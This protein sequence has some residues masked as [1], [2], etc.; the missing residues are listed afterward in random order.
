MCSRPSLPW[1]R[2]G[3]PVA[4][5]CT[6]VVCDAP[7]GSATPSDTAATTARRHAARIWR[8]TQPRR[9]PD[10]N[11]RDLLFTVSPFVAA[12]S[13]PW[14][15]RES[16]PEASTRQVSARRLGVFDARG[17]PT[18][19]ASPTARAGRA[20]APQLLPLMPSVELRQG[21]G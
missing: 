21:I 10:I 12:L 11:R 1:T 6:A 16:L 20:R 19:H 3:A 15:E 9:S 5:T 8:L 18:R 4:A 13:A 7:A 17:P 14:P 2:C